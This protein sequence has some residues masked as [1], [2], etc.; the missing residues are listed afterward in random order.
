VLV[1]APDLDLVDTFHGPQRL[2]PQFAFVFNGYIASL[3]QLKSWVDGEVF[4]G[5]LSEGLGPLGFAGIPLPL[6]QFVAF[7]AAELED[8]TVIA[9]KLYAM[10]RID[11]RRAKVT[12]FHAHCLFLYVV[13]LKSLPRP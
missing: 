5:G 1:L 9:H 2:G 6:E 8:F 13:S 3:L 11:R 4:A 10:A 12:L 7:T